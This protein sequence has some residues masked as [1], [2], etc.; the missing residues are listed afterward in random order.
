MFPVVFFQSF[1]TSIFAHLSATMAR[2]R[3]SSNSGTGLPEKEAPLHL[4][5][6][7]DL[8]NPMSETKVRYMQHGLTSE[9]ADWLLSLSEKEKSQIY[10]KVDFRLV[11][12]L[13]LLYLVRSTRTQTN[14]AMLTHA[15]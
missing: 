7:V 2:S 11:P 4:E 15:R 12:M 8:E 13:A 1:C 3:G 10:R 9:E 14:R 6:L 5:Q